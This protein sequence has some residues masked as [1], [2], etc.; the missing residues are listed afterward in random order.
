MPPGVPD[1]RP[2][3][4]YPAVKLVTP[5]LT[6]MPVWLAVVMLDSGPSG[7]P[8]GILLVADTRVSCWK[9]HESTRASSLFNM[10]YTSFRAFSSCRTRLV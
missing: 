10:L 1:S 5:S 6:Q 4:H 9:K 7:V 2:V 3:A 8:V